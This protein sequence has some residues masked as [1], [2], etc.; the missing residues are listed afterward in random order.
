[1]EAGLTLVAEAENYA[2]SVFERAKGIRDGLMIAL[3]AVCPVRVKNFAALEIGVTFK[4]VEGT[5]GLSLPFKSTKTKG[6]EERP[7]PEFLNHAIDLYLKEAR[8]C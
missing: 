3:L 7:V 5:G 2:K 4:E 8:P 6:L 1:M